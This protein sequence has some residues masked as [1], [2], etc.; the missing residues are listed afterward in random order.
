MAREPA[1]PP[2]GRPRMVFQ[3]GSAPAPS[4]PGPLLSIRPAA[5]ALPLALV[6]GILAWWGWKSGA[7]FDPIFLP[8]TIVLLLLGVALL[9]F[10]PWPAKLRGP[11][12]VALGALALLAG[13]TL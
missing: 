6:A 13:W 7:Y 12:A 4:R 8:G 5:A 1:A 10:A 3:A 9:A 11:P 2:R